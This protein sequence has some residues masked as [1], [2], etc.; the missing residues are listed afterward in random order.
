MIFSLV[1]FT[2]MTFNVLRMAPEHLITS[3]PVTWLMV[4]PQNKFFP[5]VCVL[6]SPHWWVF[7]AGV[8]QIDT[9]PLLCWLFW[10]ILFLLSCQKHL[11]TL[12]NVFFFFLVLSFSISSFHSLPLFFSFLFLFSRSFFLFLTS[13]FSLWILRC[14]RTARRFLSHDVVK[15][16]WLRQWPSVRF[17]TRSLIRTRL[18]VF[19][20]FNGHSAPHRAPHRAAPYSA[21]SSHTLRCSC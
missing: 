7:P 9:P 5:S 1:M 12:I 3:P 2:I 20:L 4:F 13:L 21:G 10:N 19:H 18:A 6:L 14:L 16:C 11:T 17:Y 8:T 15:S